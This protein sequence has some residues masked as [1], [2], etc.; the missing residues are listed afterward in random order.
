M[1]CPIGYFAGVIIITEDYYPCCDMTSLNIIKLYGSPQTTD[2]TRKE[3]QKSFC[4]LK[5]LVHWLCCLLKTLLSSH[6]AYAPAIM[7][8]HA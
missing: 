6:L 2:L 4:S 5:S 8:T 1:E 7:R 3:I